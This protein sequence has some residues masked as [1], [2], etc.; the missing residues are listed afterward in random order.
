MMSLKVDLIRKAGKGLSPAIMLNMVLIYMLISPALS[1]DLS[2]DS[3]TSGKKVVITGTGNPNSEHTFQSS[4][5]MNL[6]VTSGRY[7]YETEVRVP[8]KPNRFTFNAGNVENLDAAVKLGI[9]ITKSFDATSGEVRVSRDNVPPGKYRLKISGS[10]IPGYSQVP[11]AVEAETQ[12]QADSKGR[13]RLDIDTTGIP[14]GEYIID[15][16]GDTKTVQI[17]SKKNPS[18]S[19]SGGDKLKENDKTDKSELSPEG[20]S[21]P[22]STVS[23]SEGTA[24]SNGRS[25][26]PAQPEKNKGI[27][28]ILTGWFGI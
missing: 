14:E 7:S 23:G 6:P 18:S 12:V 9:W 21:T 19:P 4:F 13:Y 16:D 17:V 22:D 25:A 24:G 20:S 8:K 11:I 26:P 3:V 2:S 28:D 1:F 5:T 27:A 15:G 10:A